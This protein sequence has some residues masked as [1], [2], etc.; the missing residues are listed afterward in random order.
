M[1]RRGSRQG[2][3]DVLRDNLRGKK[4]K[5]EPTRKGDRLHGRC[6]GI[7]IGSIASSRAPFLAASLPT[8]AFSPVMCGVNGRKGKPQ[9]KRSPYP[10]SW[11]LA[12]IDPL[13]CAMTIPGCLDTERGRT[14]HGVAAIA[15]TLRRGRVAHAFSLQKRTAVRALS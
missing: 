15:V 6:W 1:N 14:A 12:C 13:T 7:A 8:T 5:G 11:G 3:G 10:G 9:K 2:G 4:D